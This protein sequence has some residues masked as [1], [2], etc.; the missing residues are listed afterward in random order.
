MNKNKLSSIFLSRVCSRWYYLRNSKYREDQASFVKK[1]NTKCTLI[2]W[3][4]KISNRKSNN[5]FL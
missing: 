1:K 2:T 4:A 3:T 5:G